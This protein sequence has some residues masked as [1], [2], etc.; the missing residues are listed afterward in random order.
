M[1]QKIYKHMT[2][3]HACSQSMTYGHF[4]LLV[5]QYFASVI[6]FI[7][8]VM[9]TGEVE[10]NIRKLQTGVCISAQ[11][12]VLKY[13]KGDAC[14][15]CWLLTKSRQIAFHFGTGV[16][17]TDVLALYNMACTAST[18]FSSPLFATLC[19]LLRYE[20]SSVESRS[21]RLAAPRILLAK[22]LHALLKEQSLGWSAVEPMDHITYNN[23]P[24]M[25]FSS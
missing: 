12:N 3:Y 24:D 21:W 1:T 5:S 22:K 9:G 23:G 2:R 16:F 7:V 15:G 17:Q 10:V 20:P 4:P 11:A 8:S 19:K 18:I 14:V 6:M 25:P 13:K